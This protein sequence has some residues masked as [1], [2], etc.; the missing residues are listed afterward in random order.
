MFQNLLNSLY[1]G[2]AGK[3]DYTPEHLPDS[4]LKLFFETLKVRWTSL[5]K[6][7]V[8]YILFLLPALVWG[9]F[10]YLTLENLIIAYSGGEMDYAAF[11]EQF[12]GLLWYFL[13]ILWPCIA[14]TGPAT[15]GVSYVT[16]NWARDQHSFMFSDFKDAMKANWK[17][18]LATSAITG[19]MPFVF[20]NCWRFY[21]QM[22]NSSSVL[23]VIP[24][25]VVLLAVLIWALSQQLMYTMMITYQ[26][27]FKHLVKNSVIL[28]LGKLP[29]AVGI[30]LLTLAIPLIVIL[31][32]VMIP[33]TS[34]YALLVLVLYYLL[35]GFAFS[36]FASA[37]FA[38]AV[39]EGYINPRIEG[40]DTNIGLRQVT[41]DDY[42]IDPTLPQPENRTGDDE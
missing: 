11:V 35:F 8:F 23:F 18:G 9:V 17:Q 28:T 21:G 42:E 10:N 19:A 37:S 31:V 33:A 2:K 25:M 22:S 38:N 39:C 32:M 27:R 7:N 34:V 14:I 15:A 3:G 4:R 24:Q 16:R 36:R 20:F 41:D 6:L 40:A 1:Y 26:L 30:R 29:L 5:I 12:Q 13:L